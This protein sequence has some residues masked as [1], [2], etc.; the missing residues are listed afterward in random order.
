MT[1]DQAIYIILSA[2]QIDVIDSNINAFK[3]FPSNSMWC[4]S[5]IKLASGYPGISNNP[6]VQEALMVLQAN[7]ISID[8][9]IP[10]TLPN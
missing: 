2:A 10:P 4:K 3:N 6:L 1:L 9:G 5:V 7:G 8:T